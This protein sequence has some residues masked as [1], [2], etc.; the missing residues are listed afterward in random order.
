MQLCLLRW[1]LD[2]AMICAHALFDVQGQHVHCVRRRYIPYH[3][4]S[5]M[6]IDSSLCLLNVVSVTFP[7]CTQLR[8][9]AKLLLLLLLLFDALPV[10][11][12][13]AVPARVSICQSC[14]CDCHTLQQKQ[15]CVVHLQKLTRLV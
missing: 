15:G 8:Y 11:P 6:G 1:W 4:W 5:V 9:P 10:L 7:G 14:L 12:C 13:V 2:G 3:M